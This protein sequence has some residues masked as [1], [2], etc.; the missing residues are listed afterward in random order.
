MFQIVL[1]HRWQS[2]MTTLDHGD[3][4]RSIQ[5]SKSVLKLATQ[6]LA[7]Q[8][9]QFCLRTI[10][11]ALNRIS[12]LM[13]RRDDARAKTSERKQS[14]TGGFVR[15]EGADETTVRNAVHWLCI[16]GSKF[17]RR[18]IAGYAQGANKQLDHSFVLSSSSPSS[19]SVVAAS[20]SSSSSFSWTFENDW[21]SDRVYAD[22]L[23]MTLNGLARLSHVDDGVAGC[24]NVNVEH[25]A[26]AEGYAE[27][28]IRHALLLAD[29]LDD[30]RSISV[31]LYAL[32]LLPN[33][34][35][36]AAFESRRPALLHELLYRVVVVAP[37][38]D[39]LSMS[40]TLGA[41]A[42]MNRQQG[43]APDRFMLVRAIEAL[44]ASDGVDDMWSNGTEQVASHALWALARL[45]PREHLL[46]RFSRGVQ[47]RVAQLVDHL[48]E[49]R[50]EMTPRAVSNIFYALAYVGEHARGDAVAPHSASMRVL[51]ERGVQA[52]RSD[53][54]NVQD[55][56]NM[57]WALTMLGWV[58]ALAPLADAA[59]A[60]AQALLLA[61]S[62]TNERLLRAM[63]A[64]QRSGGGIDVPEVATWQAKHRFVQEVRACQTLGALE[65]LLDATPS[66]SMEA[67]DVAYALEWL[68]RLTLITAHAKPW[69]L[70]CVVLDDKDIDDCDGDGVR[71]RQRLNATLRV[72]VARLIDELR[73]G[74]RVGAL[75]RRH[76][77]IALEA[78]AQ[79]VVQ[80]VAMNDEY[81]SKASRLFIERCQRAML[82]LSDRVDAHIDRL[83]ARDIVAVL[84]ALSHID[85]QAGYLHGALLPAL[86]AR[87]NALAAD[88]STDDFPVLCTH[89]R[90]LE[91][92]A[93]SPDDPL[94]D[95]LAR[96][97]SAQ[98][99][100]PLDLSLLSHFMYAA[101][102]FDPSLSLSTT[103][104]LVASLLEPMLDALRQAAAASPSGLG[105]M[106]RARV[107][108]CAAFALQS[109]ARIIRRA[110]DDVVRE[111]LANARLGDACDALAAYVGDPTIAQSTSSQHIT[112]LLGALMPL[113]ALGS[114][115]ARDAFFAFVV[116]ATECVAANT[117]QGSYDQLVESDVV[118]LLHWLSHMD[119]YSVSRDTA[120]ER[121]V[122]ARCVQLAVAECKR[123]VDTMPSRSVRKLVP[124]LITILRQFNLER[125]EQIESLL[126]TLR[127]VHLAD[128]TIGIERLQQDDSGDYSNTDSDLDN[129][130][131]RR[132]A[133]HE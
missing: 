32:S 6:V 122:V 78:L 42:H 29:E 51:A 54:C 120:D 14:A 76:L 119:A 19:P 11:Y 9:D 100:H 93:Q 84:E 90:R 79:L 5:Q 63:S 53:E 74:D 127:R 28:A 103:R 71:R 17:L 27:L 82:L 18:S 64:C 1:R 130:D 16:V 73:R 110:D 62:P 25:D 20:S 105:Q 30:A 37:S 126:A 60:R 91:Y 89:F 112:M 80:A 39:S 72:V 108:L 4:M 92:A 97:A 116:R 70:S 131:D 57:L 115:P 68:A 66:E 45:K 109:L 67:D 50:N 128:F 48:A 38:F 2:T 117:S 52:M 123:Y 86:A 12:R 65:R 95:L 125:S 102:H 8:P 133:K 58:D 13:P 107:T 101:A 83:G 3:V 31:M 69:S 113:A 104:R 132:Q 21:Q 124:A 88:F 23:T 77:L 56:S 96:R 15:D 43:R 87:A 98:R 121:A 106:P 61:S 85:G 118:A 59:M 22:D 99:S 26:I 55:A 41:L 33:F 46:E 129:F 10:S 49:L 75:D 111:L 47:P 81:S 114:A 24:V 44:A 94:I 36:R 35:A 7:A 40:R 34:G